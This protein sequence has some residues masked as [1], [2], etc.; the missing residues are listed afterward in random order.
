MQDQYGQNN[1]WIPRFYVSITTNV[2]VSE[3]KW[4][5][6]GANVFSHICINKTTASTAQSLH[7][8]KRE[9]VKYC[10]QFG[11]CNHF[12]CSSFLCS[13]PAPAIGRLRVHHK[14]NYTQPHSLRSIPIKTNILNSNNIISVKLQILQYQHFN[15]A[16]P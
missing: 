3:R 2:T 10:K 9:I 4:N 8:F 1:N 6:K 14:L 5:Y 15:I 7:H 12:S 13:T 16:T 11:Y